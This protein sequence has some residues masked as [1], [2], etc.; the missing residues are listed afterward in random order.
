MFHHTTTTNLSNFTSLF[1]V[2]SFVL[3]AFIILTVQ[4]SFNHTSNTFLKITH[5]SRKCQQKHCCMQVQSSV[6]RVWRISFEK[7]Y[8]QLWLLL[9]CFH[10]PLSYYWSFSLGWRMEPCTFHTAK[11]V[12]NVTGQDAVGDP[13]VKCTHRKWWTPSYLTSYNLKMDYKLIMQA[14]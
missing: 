1:N 10:F 11:N 9:C 6:A 4:T 12:Q 5:Q 8:H 3:N 2:L 14:S 7:I 13:S